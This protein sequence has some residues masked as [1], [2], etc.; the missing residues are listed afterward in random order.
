MKLR[1]VLGRQ[2]IDGEFA[3]FQPTKPVLNQ[4][5]DMGE[6]EMLMDGRI[7]FKIGAGEF[8]QRGRRA[9]PIFLQMNESAG[10][11]DEPLIKRIIRPLT[12]PEPKLLQ[13]IVRL[14]KKRPV[15]AFKIPEVMRVQILTP[16]T[17]DQGRDFGALFTHV[18]LNC[19]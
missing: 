17:V 4:A 2:R 6:V 18:R 9:Q 8:E 7:F 14:I 3:R 10:E 16:A 12:I 11:L 5:K 13:H 15:E 1:S 19:R